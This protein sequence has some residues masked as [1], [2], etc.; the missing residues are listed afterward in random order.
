MPE[1]LQVRIIGIVQGVGFRPFVYRLAT[2]LE[3]TGWVLNDGNGVTLEVEGAHD[4]L[5]EFLRRVRTDAPPA[6]Y[7]YAVDHRFLEVEGFTTFEIRKSG[8]AGAAQVWILPDLATCNA[9]LQDIRDPGNRRRRY[10]FTNCTHCGPRFTILEEVPYDRPRTSM[11]SFRMCSACSREYEDPEDRRFHAQPVACDECG[12]RVEF[13]TADRSV[14]ETGDPAMRRAAEAIRN[15]GILAVKGLGGY[16]L[17]VDARNEASV[18]ELRR[19]KRRPNKPFAV[20]YPDEAAL[21][22]HVEVPAVAAPLL[23]S[24]QAPIL[25]LPRTRHG[26]DEIAPSVAPH[27]PYLGVFL[28]YTPLHHLLLEDLGFPVVATSGNITDEPIQFQDEEASGRLQSLCDGWLVH[29]RPIVNPADDS[30]LQLVTRPELKLQQLRRARGYT[31]MPILA[32]RDL[33]PLL[34]LG[35]HLNAT[36]AISRGREIILSQHLGDL[37][38]YDSRQLYERTLD[39]FLKLYRVSPKAV[40]HDMHPDYFTTHL[41]ARLGLPTI[42]V[43]HHHAH[44]AACLLE[45]QVTSPALGITWDGT[46]FGPDHTVWGGEFLAGSA[47][48]FLRIASLYPF[49]LPSGEK[50]IKETWRTALSLLWEAYGDD[51]PRALPMFEAVP[52]GRIDGVLQI[53]RRGVLSPVTTSAGRLFDGISALLGLTYENTHQA[54]AAQ[55]VEYAAWRCTE[56]SQPI[57]IP[58]ENGDLLRLDWRPLIRTL[59]DQFLAGAPLERLAAS[60]HVSLA[61][62]AVE[63]AKR[64]AYETVI[65]AGGVFCN[66]YLTE[67]LASLLQHNGFHPCIHSQLP[68]TDGSLSAGQLWVAAN[69]SDFRF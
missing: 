28:P 32:P 23:L 34:A 52:K 33:P 6:A 54:E 43:Q 10:P 8:E 2:Q 42:A 4:R 36:F 39:T 61:A 46:G 62:A 35:G 22:R 16:H 1:R 18:A 19:R 49:R 26:V 64:A 53:L 41:A 57:A 7:L 31:P 17:V 65:L 40:A 13:R 47:Q 48:G 50:A 69:N 9:C 59:V 37:E 44:F 45:N 30:V 11:K 3:L 55:L 63:V 51:F 15:G 58:I 67:H 20:M 27:S 25:L 14:H 24:T 21:R 68:P 12:P 5:L 38:G 60:F 66:R 56:Q 29:N